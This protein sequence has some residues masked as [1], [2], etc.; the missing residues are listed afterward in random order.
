VLDRYFTY[1]TLAFAVAR[2]DTDFRLAVDT[3]LSQLF[4]SGGVSEVY[5]QSF[6]PIS[7]SAVTFFDLVA[8]E[9]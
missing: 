8:L 5:A 1:E 7:A 3:A 4:R 9:E 2:D 6:G